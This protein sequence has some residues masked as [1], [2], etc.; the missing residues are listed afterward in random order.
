MTIKT[1]HRPLSK[2]VR[3]NNVYL[4][5]NF[6]RKEDNLHVLAIHNNYNDDD[7]YNREGSSSDVMGGGVT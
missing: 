2:H 4:T 5:I 6:A 1:Y 7:R 3:M